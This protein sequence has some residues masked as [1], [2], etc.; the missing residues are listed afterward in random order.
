LEKGEMTTKDE[1]FDVLKSHKLNLERLGIK[2]IGVF[3][4]YVRD[5][6]TRNSDIDLLI[7]FAPEHE[8]FENL[9]A[10][11]DLL[12]SIFK[13]EKVEVVTKNGLSPHMAP[14]ILQEV[15]YV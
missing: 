12:E 5:E 11:Y 6:Q 13:D 10:V 3:G 2:N 1:I 4:S 15:S 14:K 9:M 7:D 8:N